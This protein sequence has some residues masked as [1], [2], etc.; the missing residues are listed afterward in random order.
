LLEY[1]N[2]TALIETRLF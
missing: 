1:L 2:N